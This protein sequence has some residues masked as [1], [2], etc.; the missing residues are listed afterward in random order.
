MIQIRR[1]AQTFQAVLTWLE[2]S[3]VSLP[4]PGCLGV[5]ARALQAALRVYTNLPG[6]KGASAQMLKVTVV[7]RDWIGEYTVW[8]IVNVL[9]LVCTHVGRDVRCIRH[10]FVG[11]DIRGT[12]VSTDCPPWGVVR[13]RRALRRGNRPAG[14]SCRMRRR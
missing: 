3:P 8:V 11:D 10:R 4:L 7:K 14:L 13:R 2:A 6:T 1:G 9:V 12:Q 5:R